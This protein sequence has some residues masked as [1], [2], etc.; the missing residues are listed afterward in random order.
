LKFKTWDNI[1][2]VHELYTL[3]IDCV[4]ELYTLYIDCVHELYTLHIDCVHE[5]YTLYK[6]QQT[7]LAITV[8]FV[9]Q[10]SHIILLIK[11][12]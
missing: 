12:H 3:Y 11:I 2:C 8:T 1:D 4:H 5:L 9:Q 10:V 7:R 6:R